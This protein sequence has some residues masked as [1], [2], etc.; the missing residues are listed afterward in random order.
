[1]KKIILNCMIAGALVALMFF[2]VIISSSVGLAE[3]KDIQSEG[4]SADSDHLTI[5]SS[6]LLPFAALRDGNPV[7]FGVEIVYEIMRRLERA[8][9]IEFDDW[10]I[11]YKRV[12]TEPNTVLMPPSRTLEREALFKWVGPLIPEKIVLF[13][14]KDSGLIIKSPKDAKKVG[15][16]ATVSGYASEKLLKAMGFTN[17][18][19]QRSPLQGPDALKFGRVDLWIN[20]NITMKKTALAAGVDPDL[21][22]PVFV[23]KEIPSY[24]AFSKSVPD[25]LVN[26]WQAALD[27]M[28]QD[29]TWERIVSGWVPADLLRIGSP[30][31]QLAMEPYLALANVILACF[32]SIAIFS[33]RSKGSGWLS[34][35]LLIYGAHSMLRWGMFTENHNIMVYF[36]VIS[37]PAVFL[38]G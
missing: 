23:L 13:A 25:H 2:S 16:I 28:K 5:L 3:T 1:M 31:R 26:Q 9:S 33:L 22:E 24:L 19:S 7:G 29:G 14:R 21:F 38:L 4:V 20:S 30:P 11:V 15:S 27:D 36:P 8:D 37:F 18:A 32:L 6:E 10:D 12:L 35:L 17:L 34:L